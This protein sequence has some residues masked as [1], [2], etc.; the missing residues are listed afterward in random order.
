M[1]F[2]CLFCSYMVDVVDYDKVEFLKNEFYYLLD[3]FQLQGI[4]VLVFG[5][6][7]DL[8]GVLDEKELIERM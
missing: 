4:L 3:K 5:N 7:R 6:K 1:I 8:L 2:L